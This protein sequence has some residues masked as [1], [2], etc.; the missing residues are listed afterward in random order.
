VFGFIGVIIGPVF[1]TI[2]AALLCFA[3]WTPSSRP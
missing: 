3:D 2:A 1:L